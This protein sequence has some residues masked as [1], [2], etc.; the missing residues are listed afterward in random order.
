MPF[1]DSR[2]SHPL[3]AP[4]R[5]RLTPF[6]VFLDRNPTLLCDDYPRWEHHYVGEPSRPKTC[7]LNRL[8][9]DEFIHVSPFDLRRISP[10]EVP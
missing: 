1:A 2:G 8:S 6:I 3:R 10:V 4:D 5:S 7:T 9:G